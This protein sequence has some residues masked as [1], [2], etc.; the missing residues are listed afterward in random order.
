MLYDI[1]LTVSLAP[2]GKAETVIARTN[3][4]EMYYSAAQQL[5]QR[6]P[7]TIWMTRCSSAFNPDHRPKT[8]LSTVGPMQTEY[9]SSTWSWPPLRP[10]PMPFLCITA[11][12]GVVRTV[13][14]PAG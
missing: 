10:G 7:T 6:S 13:A 3:Y 5:A 14:S 1:G 2:G 9:Q 8:V 11:C 12:F 4:R